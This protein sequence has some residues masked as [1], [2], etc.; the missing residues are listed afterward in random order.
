MCLSPQHPPSHIMQESSSSH[1]L[2]TQSLLPPPF[3]ID[4]CASSASATASSA[5]EFFI[6]C[7][8]GIGDLVRIRNLL[9][10]GKI[11]NGKTAV[12]VALPPPVPAPPD[13]A[14][15]PAPSAELLDRVAVWPDCRSG[16]L[17]VKRQHLQRLE[18]D[19]EARTHAA[20][21]FWPGDEFAEGCPVALRATEQPSA[22]S[23]D[24]VLVVQCLR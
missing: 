5:T 22:N 16:L 19:Y 24:D 14:V 15:R 20:I 6:R 1:S 7:E 9:H 10:N 11:H 4:A 12:V 21:A 3:K 8:L 13:P 17:R 23:P 2:S 18:L